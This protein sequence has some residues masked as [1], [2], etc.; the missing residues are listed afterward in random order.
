MP[1]ST[2]YDLLKQIRANKELQELPVIFV[3]AESNPLL[4]KE[5]EEAGITLLDQKTL[6]LRNFPE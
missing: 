3:T 1:D 6:S 2:G 4:M 5:A